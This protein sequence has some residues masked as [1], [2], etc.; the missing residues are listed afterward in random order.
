MRLAYFV[1]YKLAKSNKVQQV[2]RIME[3]TIYRA[4]LKCKTTSIS[5]HVK[6]KRSVLYPR[7]E[8]FFIHPSLTKPSMH[9]KKI[10]ES[11]K[12]RKNAQSLVFNKTGGGGLTPYGDIQ[13]PYCDMKNHHNWTKPL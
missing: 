3:G 8:I 10:K 12:K 6:P 4:N 2:A 9:L 7:Y 1:R 13:R 5:C 11:F